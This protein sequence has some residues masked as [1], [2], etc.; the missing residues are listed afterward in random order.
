MLVIVNTLSVI[1]RASSFSSVSLKSKVKYVRCFTSQ[2]ISESDVRVEAR[3]HRLAV[4]WKNEQY[5]SFPD[6]VTSD[7]LKRKTTGSSK[8]ADFSHAETDSE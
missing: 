6:F 7:L 3:I 8:V 5:A 4:G 2:I 1:D